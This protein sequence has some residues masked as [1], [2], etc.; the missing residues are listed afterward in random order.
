M[1]NN[2]KRPKFLNLF[3]I[4]LPVTGVNSIA[5]RVSGAIM[6]LMIP[7]LIYLFSLSVK[8]AEGFQQVVTIL[9]SQSSKIIIT[10]LAWALGH[11][12]MAGIRFLLTDVDVGTELSTARKTAWFV[13]V[14]AVIFF[15][16]IAYKI[17]V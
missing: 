8:N 3:R 1:K 13:N 2:N 12:L 5:H 16:L 4:R 14:T 17:W 11:H 6:F 10:I 9:N 7:T 15:I